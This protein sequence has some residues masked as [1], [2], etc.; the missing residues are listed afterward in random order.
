[1]CI[2]VVIYTF[3]AEI[4]CS[5]KTTKASKGG[6]KCNTVKKK[7]KIVSR[8]K[9]KNLFSS[10]VHQFQ[11]LVAA[12]QGW[13]FFFFLFQ[14]G[15]PHESHTLFLLLG[16]HVPTKQQAVS[17]RLFFF[18]LAGSCRSPE[19]FSLHPSLPPSSFAFPP[20]PL[21]PLL[22]CAPK[23]YSQMCVWEE[24]GQ[25]GKKRVVETIKAN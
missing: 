6:Q 21:F 17:L 18:L 11:S 2:F 10:P 24:K 8:M 15:S 12:V 9:V 7:H 14:T 3:T 22:C 5:G 4:S 19:S 13:C 23:R 20:P 25:I 16:A 1:M